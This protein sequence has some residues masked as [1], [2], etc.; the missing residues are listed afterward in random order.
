VSEAWGGF[1][2]GLRSAV[3]ALVASAA[4]VLVL[5]GVNAGVFTA[6]SPPVSDPS[7]AAAHPDAAAS[8]PAAVLPD[9]PASPPAAVLPDV[10]ADVPAPQP[11]PHSMPVQW[12][13]VTHPTS[14]RRVAVQRQPVPAAHQP[15]PVAPVQ[16]RQP[17]SPPP[18]S[19]L[20][21]SRS[22][23]RTVNTEPCSCDGSMRRVPTHWD[24]PTD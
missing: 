20:P 12:E 6:P 24:P 17:V 16:N 5:A 13:P 7:P 14:Y 9:V 4:L 11:A 10:P 23:S 18:V 8:P 2:L 1:V 3:I 21:V 19:A 15:V 22:K